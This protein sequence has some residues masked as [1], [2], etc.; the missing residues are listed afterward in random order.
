MIDLVTV[1]YS[2]VYNVLVN[3]RNRLAV[4]CIYKIDVSILCRIILISYIFFSPYNNDI[5]SILVLQE[6]TSKVY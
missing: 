2:A 3:I 4:C 5:I 6:A 1:N